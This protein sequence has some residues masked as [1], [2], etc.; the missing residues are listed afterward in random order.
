M[1]EVHVL[2][3]VQA[4][5]MEKI[6]VEPPRLQ[7]GSVCYPAGQYIGGGHWRIL[8]VKPLPRSSAAGT[9]SGDDGT[10]LTEGCSG[11][12]GRLLSSLDVWRVTSGRA[13]ERVLFLGGGACK[14]YLSFTVVLTGSLTSSAW[15]CSCPLVA[16]LLNGLIRSSLAP[17]L[18]PEVKS[19]CLS[20]F[21][22]EITS[23]GHYG[24]QDLFQ[25][26]QHVW[27]STSGEESFR[28]KMPAFQVRWSK[29]LFQVS[30]L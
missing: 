1:L 20:L 11:L 29:F 9:P 16:T 12:S 14:P 28:C 5:K 10:L 4:E 26:H 3:G 8:N 7:S 13:W 21:R 30:R 6:Q 22:V 15:G 18:K 25:L 17:R 24:Q 2:L 27:W 23:E 19:L